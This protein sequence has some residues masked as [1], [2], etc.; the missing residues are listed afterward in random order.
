MYYSG[1]CL[2]F[3]SL[4]IF[5]HTLSDLLD[6]VHHKGRIPVG[7]YWFMVL[8]VLL[9]LDLNRRS[10]FINQIVFIM[11]QLSFIRPLVLLLFGLATTYVGVSQNYPFP[12]NIDYAGS[13][14]Q[15]NHVTPIELNDKTVQLYEEWKTKYLY[16]DCQPDQY[17]VYF[18]DGSGAINVSEGQGYG[19]MIVAYMAGY[20]VYARDYFDGLYRFVEAHPSKINL[21]LMDWKQITCNDQASSDDDAASD[22]DIDIAFALLLAHAQWGSDGDIDYL[23]RAQLVIEAIMKDEI[24]ANEWTV[25]LGDWATKYSPSYFNATRPSD[26]ITDH[27]R[28]FALVTENEN[29]E[30]VIEQCYR[31]IDL[32]QTAYSPNTGLMPDFIVE[33]NGNPQ[34]A[35]A[36]FLEG[37]NDGNYSYNACRVPWRIGLD[38]LL[39]ADARA[40]QSVEKMNRWLIEHT[41]GDPSKITDEY[42]LDG[43]VMTT[44]N[45]PIFTAPF[46]V[47]AMCDTA[48]QQWLNDL[49][50]L[51][52]QSNSSSQ[53]YYSN[54]IRL[55]SM[56]ALSG[57]YWAPEEEHVVAHCRVRDQLLL[58]PNPSSGMLFINGVRVQTDCFVVYN[59]NGQNVTQLVA[60]DEIMSSFDVSR[61]PIGLY[62]LKIEGETLRFYRE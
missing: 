10:I 30:L 47:G 11:Y 57:N 38:H 51:V 48:N 29:W 13:F 28:L 22:G 62:L 17:Y 60:F 61:L 14:I 43:Q 16:N 15:P 2:S 52:I 59:N 12:Q 24:N 58:Y 35:S 32:M 6:F 18:G 7:L 49:Y 5:K 36:N 53:G 39:Y 56:L 55:L 19:M 9:C 34:P 31:L 3:V 23:S 25:K 8:F 50:D 20:D 33:V 45:S 46:A 37:S 1:I 44:W 4:L 40:Q 27:F 41:S 21:N 26:F 54:S 42:T